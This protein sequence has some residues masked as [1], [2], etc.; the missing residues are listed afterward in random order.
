MPAI[1]LERTV[2][3]YNTAHASENK[4][5]DDATAKRFGFAGGLVPGVD[6]FAYMT[7]PALT[8]WGRAWLEG[9]RLS[10][11]FMKPVYDGKDIKVIAHGEAPMTVEVRFG[12][13]VCA[14]G[15]AGLVGT[16]ESETR[17]D[18][19]TAPL[20]TERPTASPDSL[21]KGT[22]MGTLELRLDPVESETYRRDVRDDLSIFEGGRIAHPGWLLR[23]AN[24]V[25]AETVKLSP[26]IHVASDVR[27]Q[28]ILQAGEDISVRGKV[29]DNY[30]HKGHKFV[31]LDVQI[32]T[33]NGQPIMRADH[34]AIYAPRQV[35]E[36]TG[37]A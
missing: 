28:G 36:G 23:R 29:R 19:P 31:E 20:P 5:H 34:T 13:T 7:H 25:L 16:D 33:H 14:A 10:A 4:I 24:R 22:V 2:N 17:D 11:R 27:F 26:W 12:E 15:E 18:V 3:A 30:E 37:S 1:L 21:A 6:V 35:A 9:G 32:V 8:H